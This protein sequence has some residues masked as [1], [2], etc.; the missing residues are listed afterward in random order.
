MSGIWMFKLMS[1]LMPRRT[2][3]MREQW[4]AGVVLLER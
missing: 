3:R 1:R 4:R 2:A